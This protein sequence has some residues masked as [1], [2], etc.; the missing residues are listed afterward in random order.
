M[1]YQARHPRLQSKIVTYWFIRSQGIPSGT[2]MLP[3]GFSDIMINLGAP[4]RINRPGGTSEEI[5]G[6]ALFGQRNTSLY[7]E[8]PGE[9]NMVGIRL[10]PGTEYSF[11]GRA[12]HNLLN[13]SLPLHE[14][15]AE[16]LAVC[17]Q[18]L[19]RPGI[20]DSEKTTAIEQLLLSLLDQHHC[21]G[22]EKT[23]AAAQL[24]LQHKGHISLDGLLQELQ[25][26]YKQA[27]RLFKKH[28]GLPPK[29]FI[30][31]HRFYHAFTRVRAAG[32]VNWMEVLHHCGYYDQAH[33]IKE[34]A[35]FAGLPPSRQASAQ[36]TLDEFFGFR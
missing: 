18:E 29:M 30:R 19:I 7:L 24:I 31:I 5:K 25:L 8:Q 22:H 9:V 6:S 33:F 15:H 26:S 34:F 13:Q 21:P 17:E 11:S 32:K 12:A 35:F 36:N 14:L 27:E 16:A 20:S 1:F 4:Y 10:Q 3:D 23:D 28:I 2:K